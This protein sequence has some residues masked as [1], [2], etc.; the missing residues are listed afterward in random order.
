ME[1]FLDLLGQR[2]KQ[3]KLVLQVQGPQVQEPQEPL[4]S[5]ELQVLK[6]LQEYKVQSLHISLMVE[7]HPLIIQ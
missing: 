2:A 3:V 7:Y 1:D 6:V 4:V 5:Q